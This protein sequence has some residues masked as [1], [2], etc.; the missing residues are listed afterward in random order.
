VSLLFPVPFTSVTSITE[1]G[2]AVT[3]YTADPTAGIITNG[4]SAA[5]DVF[6][7]GVQNI[8][9]TAS[10]GYAATESNVK[11]HVKLAA[12]E[13]VRFWWQ[14]GQQANIPAFGSAPESMPLPM[15]FAV[16]RRVMELLEPSP[17]VAGFA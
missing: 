14:Q 17:R 16:P 11:P 10:V 3:N 12:R 2:V 13:L 1:N 6:E 8:V 5:P 9:V 15:G 7:W 4:S